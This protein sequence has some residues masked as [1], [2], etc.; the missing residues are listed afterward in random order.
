MLASKFMNLDVREITATASAA[1]DSVTA[2]GTV[3]GIITGWE[4]SESSTR[5]LSRKP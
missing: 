4:P 2:T 3:F 5:V 1:D